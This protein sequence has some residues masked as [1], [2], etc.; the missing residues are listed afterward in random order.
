MVAS[1]FMA[2]LATAGILV[3][4]HAQQRSPAAVSVGSNDLGGVVRSVKGP[5]AGVWV[6]AE[7][8]DTPTR[9]AKIVVTDDRGRYLIP[10]LPKGNYQVWVR[11][12]GLV[13]SA[14]VQASL[15]ETFDLTAVPAPTPAAAAQYY[16]PIYWFSLLPVPGKN[17]FPMEHIKSQSEWLNIVKSGACQSCHALGTPGTRTIS[18]R[19]GTFKDSADAW[20]ERLQ[21]G[22]ASMFMAR[23]IS[24][25]WSTYGTRAMFHLEGGT[26]NRPRAVRLQL[27]PDPLAH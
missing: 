14:K 20:A 7:T 16:P 18:K 19:L 11:G 6:V 5:E 4:A 27:R 9:Y 17:E 3:G 8:T 26:A 2:A 24:G 12:Y 22:S 1:M 13:D 15:G 21:A 10:D 25:L 23:D